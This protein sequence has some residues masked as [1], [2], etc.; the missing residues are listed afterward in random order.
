M[1]AWFSPRDRTN[2]QENE[3]EGN[4]K[5]KQTNV[6][7]IPPFPFLGVGTPPPS[8]HLALAAVINYAR[9]V[10]GAHSPFFFIFYFARE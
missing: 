5:R 8:F 2:M 9:Y 1:P 6:E 7:L 10:P 4:K 3:G